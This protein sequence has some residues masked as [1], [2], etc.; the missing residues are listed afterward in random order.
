MFSIGILG[1][2]VWS[3][4]MYSVG[5]D[6][7]KLIFDL[8][9]YIYNN[10][11]NNLNSLEFELYYC[12]YEGSPIVGVYNT[13]F[14]LFIRNN[15]FIKNF[16]SNNIKNK[17]YN[18]DE[19][20]QIIFGSLL[21]DAK[22]ELASRSLNARLGFIQSTI[23]STYTYFLFN[24]FK[25]YCSSPPREYSYLDLRTNKTYSSLTFWTKA[26]PIFTYFYKQFYINNLKV[27]PCAPRS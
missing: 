7:L 8:N 14:N 21:G 19:I 15:R 26:L 27:V 3:H 9:F 6:V 2:I 16:A 20:R 10:L 11:I 4:H 17:V 1:F 24:I 5:L 13:N 25:F 12:L 18:E 22:L 23:H